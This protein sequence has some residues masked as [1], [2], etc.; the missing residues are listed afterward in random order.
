MS[1]DNYLVEKKKK[2]HVQEGDLVVYSRQKRMCLVLS[3]N[4]QLG[5]GFRSA[6]VL[7]AGSDRVET[8]MLQY[9]RVIQKSSN[10]CM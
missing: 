7:W 3:V 1:L 6:D 4:P 5:S 8:V 2:Q 10:F 9:L